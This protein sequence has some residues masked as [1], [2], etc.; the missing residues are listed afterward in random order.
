MTPRNVII[1][2]QSKLYSIS[3]V[4]KFAMDLETIENF[5]IIL[6]RGIAPFLKEKLQ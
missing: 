3:V 4:L 5:V 6:Q 1:L 2:R